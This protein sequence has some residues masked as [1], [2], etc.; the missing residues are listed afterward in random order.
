[1][2]NA[3][4]FYGSRKLPLAFCENLVALKKPSLAPPTEES[5]RI[6]AWIRLY[7]FCSPPSRQVRDKLE[8]M[9]EAKKKHSN[10]HPQMSHYRLFGRVYL[11]LFGYFKAVFLTKRKGMLKK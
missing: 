8:G 3:S 2:L 9:G 4:I 11:L 1:V 6:E 10:Y 7:C 5:H